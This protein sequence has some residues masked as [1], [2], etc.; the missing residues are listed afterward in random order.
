MCLRLHVRS[1][2]RLR[3]LR[4][5]ANARLIAAV[6][7][8]LVVVIGFTLVFRAGIGQRITAATTATMIPITTPEPTYVQPTS[9]PFNY[10]QPA[11]PLTW[12]QVALPSDLS[13]SAPPDYLEYDGGSVFAPAHNDASVAY[14]WGPSTTVADENLHDIRQWSLWVSNDGAAHWK[15]VTSP[16]MTDNGI[17]FLVVDQLNP[18]I[19]L[20]EALVIDPPV[21]EHVAQRFI[22]Q[23]GGV[24]WQLRAFAGRPR[25][26]EIATWSG[27][28]F[29]MVGELPDPNGGA[30]SADNFPFARS[31]DGMRTW[32]AIDQPIVVT[33]QWVTGF[34]VNSRT[35][36]LLVRTNRAGLWETRD[37]GA[38]WS[39]LPDTSSPYVQYVVQDAPSSDTWRICGFVSDGSSAPP[40]LKCSED[41]GKTWEDRANIV[42][43]TPCPVCAKGKPGLVEGIPVP[44]GIASDGA[45]IV[46]DLG[47]LTSNYQWITALYRLEPGATTWRSLGVI[48]N[49]GADPHPLFSQGRAIWTI[50]GGP[51]GVYTTTYQ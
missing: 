50:S 10:G 6:A 16:P 17:A 25:V 31:D 38:H 1:P 47:G 34:W 28:T 23:N 4:L 5:P 24:T 8:M 7:A 15:R 22:S 49:G 46:A 48:P 36:A 30:A 27:V 32:R 51:S 43:S 35:D 13:P 33:G 44:V 37:L 45:V 9:T 14:L 11:H 12:R 2:R 20:A 42:I 40:V 29:G 41:S 18:N 26:S 3:S 19:L 21:G 39:R